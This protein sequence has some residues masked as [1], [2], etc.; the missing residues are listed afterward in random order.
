MAIF[1]GCCFL[2]FR[3]KNGLFIS[4]ANGLTVAQPRARP[5]ERYDNEKLSAQRANG[6]PQEIGWP[7][8]PIWPCDRPVPQ[9]VA[10]GWA[11]GC[12]YGANGNLYLKVAKKR[13]HRFPRPLIGLGVVGHA[14]RLVAARLGIREAMHRAAVHDQLPIDPAGASRPRRPPR[15]WAAR[16]DRR[17]RAAPALYT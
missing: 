4:Q 1:Y 12:P 9:G 15:L 11:N 3:I 2:L 16:A 8:G 5:G 10:Q 13:L 7:V 6:S 14:F 17:R